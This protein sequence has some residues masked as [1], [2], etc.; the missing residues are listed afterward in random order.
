M[1]GPVIFPRKSQNTS[2][3]LCEDRRRH[4][5]KHPHQ[6]PPG[7]P[8]YPVKPCTLRSD[9]RIRFKGPNRQDFATQY[10]SDRCAR[11]ACPDVCRSL[12]VATMKLRY[13]PKAD[14]ASIDL[15][16]FK[17]GISK[18][19]VPVDIEGHAFAFDFDAEGRLV[20]IEVQNASK[21][22]PI[23]V[24]KSASPPNPAR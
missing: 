5:V 17:P 20:S 9:P 16:P 24:L 11:V 14:A 6:S 2:G 10:L 7:A 3:D 8:C 13:D 1:I 23:S 18:E 12:E 19:T 21:V 4:R 15:V 22:L